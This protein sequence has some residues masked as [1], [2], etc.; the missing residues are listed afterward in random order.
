MSDS[1]YP[2]P[3]K[4]GPKWLREAMDG[5]DKVIKQDK[6]LPGFGILIDRKPDGSRINAMGL[7]DGGAPVVYAPFQL[8]AWSDSLGNPQ[9][10]IYP[11][12]IQGDGSGMPDGFTNSTAIGLDC[13]L[14]TPQSGTRYLHLRSHSSGGE[15]TSS[16]IIDSSLYTLTDAD[17]ERSALFA[18]YTYDGTA[19]VP[20]NLAYGPADLTICYSYFSSPPVW[21][22]RLSMSGGVL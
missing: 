11:S 22:L 3:V 8:V 14:G 16:E 19:I 18:S 21:T 4:K 5:R 10:L 9:L 17:N 1:D 15:Y 12:A 2:K 13:W 20:Q 7:G 6:P